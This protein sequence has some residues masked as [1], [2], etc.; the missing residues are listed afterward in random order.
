MPCVSVHQSPRFSTFHIHHLDDEG[1]PP[2]FSH[3]PKPHRVLAWVGG[4]KQGTRVCRGALA[5][6][7]YTAGRGGALY[8]HAPLRCIHYSDTQ[9]QNKHGPRGPGNPSFVRPLLF[10]P[11]CRYSEGRSTFLFLNSLQNAPPSPPQPPTKPPPIS[12]PFTPLKPPVSA[13]GVC[14]SRQHQPGISRLSVVLCGGLPP[15]LHQPQSMEHSSWLA[16]LAEN[17]PATI[18]YIFC[19]VASDR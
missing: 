11:Q 13:I 1:Q 3:L 18:N 10:S 2:S 7:S 5:T 8:D 12:P 9:N 15:C 17:T 16:S 4:P 6:D 19:D 14:V